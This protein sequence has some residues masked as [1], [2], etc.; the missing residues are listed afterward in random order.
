[1]TDSAP[2]SIDLVAARSAF[3]ERRW[4]EAHET[5][6]RLADEADLEPEDQERLAD[7]AF[8]LGRMGEVIRVRRRSFTAYKDAG[9]H[10]SAARMALHL[11][12]DHSQLLEA[13]MADGWLRRAT[14]LL[15]GTSPSAE[16]AGLGRA[17]INA[18]SHAVTSTKL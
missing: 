6:A 11:H 15:D 2:T 13:S 18:D 16:H 14:R 4:P 1:M 10:I 7:A 8:W 17:A 12:A 9:D 5:L 3:A